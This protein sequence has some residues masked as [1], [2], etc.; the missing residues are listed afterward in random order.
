MDRKGAWR[1]SPAFDVVWAYNPSGKYTHQHQ[2]SINGKRDNFNRKD[3]LAVA[4]QFGIRHAGAII[5][6]VAEAVSSWQRLAAEEEVPLAL[7]AS[8]RKSLRL[9]LMTNK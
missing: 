4:G 5:E 9:K 6:R 8:V 3:L 7:S 2:M 1:L